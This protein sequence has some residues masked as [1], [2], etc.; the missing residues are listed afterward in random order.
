MV[1]MMFSF[2]IVVAN[3]DS[4]T[5]YVVFVC[6]YARLV[7]YRHHSFRALCCIFLN[8]MH[9]V[10]FVYNLELSVILAGGFKM[11][12]RTKF[13]TEKIVGLDGIGFWE[14]V[15][16]FRLRFDSFCVEIVSV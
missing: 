15:D 8:G 9:M 5:V 11:I 2:V 4:C 1:T 6:A 12:L 16:A 7:P 14:E 3:R 10:R 13:L